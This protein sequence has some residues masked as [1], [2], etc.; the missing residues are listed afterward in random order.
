MQRNKQMA[1]GR[2]KF[3]M[4]P[5]KVSARQTPTDRSATSA[6]DAVV[7]FVSSVHKLKDK[8]G[9]MFVHPVDFVGN[10]SSGPRNSPECDMCCTSSSGHPIPDRQLPAE[11]HQR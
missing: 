4:D 7:S 11:K 5:K 1:M 10:D 3:N 8:H 9:R 2:K 6:N